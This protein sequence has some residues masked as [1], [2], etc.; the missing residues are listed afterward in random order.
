MVS[1]DVQPH[2][3]LPATYLLLYNSKGAPFHGALC[4]NQLATPLV[5]ALQATNLSGWLTYECLML[6]TL[7]RESTSH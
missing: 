4:H 7:C 3:A 5:A 1:V 2:V 6:D